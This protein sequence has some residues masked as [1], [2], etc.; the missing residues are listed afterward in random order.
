MRL[1]A[2]L[3]RAAKQYPDKVALVDADRRVG[4]R[5]LDS[6]ANQ[7]A[8][9][10]ARS[11][12]AAGDRVAIYLD[13]GADAVACIFGVLRAGAIFSVINPLTK[14]PKLRYIVENLG[15]KVV[16]TQSR[17]RSM[18]ELAFADLPNPPA[19]LLVDASQESDTAGYWAI[20]DKL[21]EYDGSTL[22]MNGLDLDLAYVAYTSGS[23]GQPKGVMMTHQSS[24][25]GAMAMNDYL[26][27]T[28]EDIIL[29]VVPLAFD[30]G[31]YQVI[32]AMMVGATVVLEKSFAFPQLVLQKLAA[33][34]A[35]GLPLVPTTASLLLQQRSLRPNQ[36]P[37]LRYIT[38][39]AAP[40]PPAHSARLQELFPNTRI[41]SNYGLTE[42]IRSTFLR[43]ELLKSKPTSVGRAMPNSEAFVIDDDGHRAG[44][45]D[46]GE[47]I[48]RGSNLFKGYWRNPEATEAVLTDGEYWWD[49]LFRTGDLFYADEDGDLYFVGRKDDIIKSR[50][51][52]VSPKEVENALYALPGIQDA[53]VVGIPD[54]V[55]GHAIKAYVVTGPGASLNTR[56]IKAHCLKHLEDYMVPQIV[57][58][59]AEIPKTESGKIKRR[60]LQSA[61]S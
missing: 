8:R 4:Y 30:Y 9:L 48:I 54:P 44:P 20:R 37:Y 49:R 57:E 14:P 28:T 39:T 3:Y 47:L 51:E 12:V 13:N 11:G 24:V 58:F 32:M 1:E 6:C 19:V 10:L 38:N 26:G 43:P 61:V 17:L 40:L 2:C 7:F 31:L 25:A 22:P 41:F 23:T 45:H 36:F 52:K 29:S 27:N 55:L 5:E 50:G 21:A 42:T 16:I 35:T 59:V 15:A 53:A 60:E 34:R 56:D 46:V 18:V 33:E